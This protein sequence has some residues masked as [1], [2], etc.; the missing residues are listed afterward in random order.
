M[1]EPSGRHD[2]DT[3]TIYE[4]VAAQFERHAAVSVYNACY[5]RPAT[6]ALLPDVEGGSVLDIGCGPGFYLAEVLARGAARVVGVDLADAMLELAR[7]RLLAA[8]GA[9]QQVELRQHDASRPFAFADA[10]FDVAISALMI[11]Y[12]DR[13]ARASVLREV[14][15]MVR[16]GGHL[17]LSS[18]HPTEDWLRKGGNYF[19]ETWITDVWKSLDYEHPVGCWRTSLDQMSAE[20]ADAG[21]VIERLVEPRPLPE[22]KV[23]NPDAYED[24]MTAPGFI[25]FR[26]RRD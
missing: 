1:S 8:A 9:G 26:L 21:F 10:S 11:H 19:E 13:T 17:V 25:A 23:I 24:L 4:A 6:L 14:H 16:P 12:L 5:D 18:V 15:R 7:P 22:A 3:R 2:P 20:F